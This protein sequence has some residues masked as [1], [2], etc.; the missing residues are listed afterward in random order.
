MSTFKKRYGLRNLQNNI[1][2]WFDHPDFGG[3]LQ[4]S[5]FGR[6]RTT[7]RW[8]YYK[9]GRQRY[10]QSKIM[11]GRPVRYG[12]LS[13]TIKVGSRPNQRGID[14]YIHRLVLETFVGPCPKG[15][16][17]RHF[18]DRNP[19]NNRLDNIQWGTPSQNAEDKRIHGT[20]LEGEANPSAKLTK[21]D[22][23][24][25]HQKYKRGHSQDAIAAQFGVTQGTI[26]NILRGEV[27]R[28]EQPKNKTPLR[29]RESVGLKNGNG[30]LN[31]KLVLAIRKLKQEGLSISEIAR[32]CG[33]KWDAAAGV[34]RGISYKDVC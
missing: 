6:I 32:R 25:I 27:Y 17:C 8:V 26:G 7:S 33:I 9:D 16:E 23:E 3:L 4:A 20:I 12:H 31:R 28:K 11:N 2:V 13:V 1:E 19:A 10:Y 15:K 21:S 14:R 29:G 34:A 30:V 22:I 5:N 18:P 24:K